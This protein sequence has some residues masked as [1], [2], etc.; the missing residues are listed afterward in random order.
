[1]AAAGGRIIAT[2]LRAKSSHIG[3]SGVIEPC[4]GIVVPPLRTLSVKVW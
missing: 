1:M 3:C 4:A 2:M